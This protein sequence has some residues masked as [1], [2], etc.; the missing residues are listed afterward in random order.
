[1]KKIKSWLLLRASFGLLW[2]FHKSY[3]YERV[4][5]QNFIMT[6]KHSKHGNYAIASWHNNCLAG[7][8]SHAKHKICLMVSRSFDGEFVAFMAKRLGMSSVRGSSS[9]GGRQALSKLTSEV[10][11]GWAAGF[12]VDGPRGPFKKVKAGAAVLAAP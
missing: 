5:E 8:L 3:R 7:I 6:R 1:M 9:R 10:A 2:L 12:T 11:S 4:Q